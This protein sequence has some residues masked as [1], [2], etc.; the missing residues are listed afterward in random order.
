MSQN[1]NKNQGVDLGEFVEFYLLDSQEQIE[2]LGAGLLQLEKEGG[3]I[4]LINDLFRS[5]H[6]LK[7][8]SG[9]MG[10]TPIVALTH[11]AEDLLDHLRQGKMDVSLEMI[12]VLLAVTDRVKA[13][14]AQVE[15]REEIS[16]EFQDLASTMRELLDGDNAAEVKG[17]QIE[18][19]DADEVVK[20][21]PQN[22][23]LTPD[24][25]E[26]VS[27]AQSLGHG[28]YQIDVK[29][30]PN[31]LMKAVRAVM[32]TQRL[33]G[34]G[35]VIKLVPSIEDLEVGNGEEFYMLVNCDEPREEIRR[36]L[37]EISELA[38]VVVHLYPNL[39]STEE[40]KKVEKNPGIDLEAA[41]ETASDTI[42]EEK[43]V[44]PAVVQKPK[45]EPKMAD[46]KNFWGST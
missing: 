3:N 13:M 43:I 22:F 39:N 12:D 45:V 27:D 4:G 46:K 17:L 20:F 37:L 6:S 18:Q 29:L 21:V 25:R 32:A 1:D 40:D 42:S 11:A 30:G 9:T 36:E 16:I 2:K 19:V 8:A 5:A 15:Q 10:F 24:E 33:E 7:G 14:L 34:I 23:Q 31:T 41:P 44:K 28:V 26:K 38:D 35:S